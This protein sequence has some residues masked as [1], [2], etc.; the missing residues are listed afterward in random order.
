MREGPVALMHRIIDRMVDHYRPEVDELED[1]LDE[2]EG[3]V[4]SQNRAGADERD[5]RRQA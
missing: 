3:R 5:P 2:I 1:W 4:I